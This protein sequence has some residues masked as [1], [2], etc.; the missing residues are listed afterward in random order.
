MTSLNEHADMTPM[1]PIWSHPQAL[2]TSQ[3][4][5][6][7]GLAVAVLCIVADQ[8]ALSANPRP[9]VNNRLWRW[10]A[11]LLLL[12]A[13][14]DWLH[15]EYTLVD[16]LRDTARGEGWYALRRPAQL[17]ILALA[18]PVVIL[19]NLRLLRLVSCGHSASA[20][21]TAI[22]G[23]S[24]LLALL[25]LRL[26]SLHYTDQLLNAHLLGAS[27][28]RWLGLAARALIAVGAARHLAHTYTYRS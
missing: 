10:C 27:V 16:W 2:D 28:G 13:L 14:A 20:Q 12:L 3:W 6:M 26:V 8:Y 17:L 24:L 7:L 4:I 11:A 18:L 21:K 5:A 9:V 25:S 23:M 22:F 1:N 19:A 15:A